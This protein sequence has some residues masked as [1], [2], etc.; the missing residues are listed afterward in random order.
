MPT[1]PEL[2]EKKAKE[3]EMMERWSIALEADGGIA[4]EY[5]A[6][7]TAIVLEN[8]WKFLKKH[9]ILMAEDKVTTSQFSGVN[10]ALIGVIRRVIPAIVGQQLVGMQAKPTPDSKV[11]TMVATRGDSKNGVYDGQEMWN[12][13]IPSRPTGSA[14][15][16]G[17]PSDYSLNVI[18]EAIKVGAPTVANQPETTGDF[19][20]AAGAVSKDFYWAKNGNRLTS[21]SMNDQTLPPQYSLILSSAV[22]MQLVGVGSDAYNGMVLAAVTFPGSYYGAGTIS[23]VAAMTQKISA[24]GALTALT[25]AV[26]TRTGSTIANTP[27]LDYTQ[28]ASLTGVPVAAAYQIGGL[29]TTDVA[30]VLSYEVSMEGNANQPELGLRIDSAD[31]GLIKRMLR[32]RYTLDAAFDMN[33]LH[34]IDLESELVNLM[35]L[36]ITNGI[37]REIVDDLRKMAAI[38][39]VLDFNNY[40]SPT[41]SNGTVTSG[42]YED[43]HRLLLDSIHQVA[44]KIWNAGRLGKGNFVVANPVTLAFLSRVN[45][46]SGSGVTANAS[47]L[48][49]TGSLGGNLKFYEDPQYPAGEF[50]IGYKGPSAMDSGYLHCPYLPVTA[51]PTM[52]QVETGDPIKIFYTRYGKTYRA[53]NP[54]NGKAN[55]NVIYAGEYQYARLSLKNLPLVLA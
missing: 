51:T 55:D 5:V 37:N 46:F 8:Y 40:V 2:E 39:S 52:N 21:I 44:A 36:D 34:G 1:N 54:K 4:D 53:F 20:F 45:G 41:P 6:R 9:P 32:G 26:V 15:I 22:S 28:P 38:N 25:G 29:A 7:Q 3:Q 23:A 43:T 30:I 35:K 10:L 42:N 47:G 50:L 13:P 12:H 33:V 48:T 11:F 16:L 49:F 19:Q 24:S 27:T 17:E 14:G 18:Q 31:T